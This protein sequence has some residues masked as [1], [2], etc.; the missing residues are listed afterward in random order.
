MIR[1]DD[2]GEHIIVERPEQLALHVLPSIYRQSRFASF[3]RQLNVRSRSAL[4]VFFTL[5]D[6]R[7]RSMASCAKSICAT[8]TP[9]STTPTPPHGPTPPSIA[10]PRP[11]WWPT[12]RDASLPVSPSR[13]S[14]TSRSCTVSPRRAPRLAWAPH[15]P[16]FPCCL[17]SRCTAGPVA[18]PPPAP[19]T[20]IR[21]VHGIPRTAETISHRSRCPNHRTFSRRT[22]RPSTR[23]LSTTIAHLRRHGV[24]RTTQ[25]HHLY[26]LS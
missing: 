20:P 11:R 12:S 8:S 4:L 7:C 9:P 23:R 3:S 13:E 6:W 10:T 21:T 5:S 15:H 17:K 14:A 25:P 24:S 26:H 19:S 16:R 18:F 2:A 22:T 1:W